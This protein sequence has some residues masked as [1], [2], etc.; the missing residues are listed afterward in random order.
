MSWDPYEG[1]PARPPYG[2][3]PEAEA[4][5]DTGGA[6]LLLGL[7]AELHGQTLHAD[8][9]RAVLC[10][11]VSGEW[12][13]EQRQEP[14]HPEINATH[15]EAGSALH[16]ACAQRLREAALALLAC[17]HFTLLNAKRTSDG[18][19]AL[20]IAAAQGMPEVVQGILAHQDL[21]DASAVDKDGFTALHGAAYCG[22]AVIVRMFLDCEQFR[23]S[24]GV[25]GAFDVLRPM[26][27]WATEAAA[28]YDMR[29]ALHMAAAGGHAAICDAILSHGPPEAT[30]ADAT[31]RVGATALHVA[32]RA[33]HTSACCAILRRPEFSAVNARDSRGFTVLHWAAQQ[34]SGDI[35]AVLLARLDFEKMEAKDLRGRT[36]V[37]IA[38]ERGHHE[39]RRL[40]L[41]RLGVEGLQSVA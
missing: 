13:A 25:L 41:Q 10:V 23:G 5:R 17:R 38:Q 3:G 31:N 4:F 16:W 35:C 28:D 24:V 37:D 21:A 30:A 11:D 15:P 29:S 40:V 6:P 32:A 36:A 27:H 20:H 7:A 39:V 19:T 1:P 8:I 14:P 12:T 9:C 18:S 22:H 34:A 33:G 26:G 2:A